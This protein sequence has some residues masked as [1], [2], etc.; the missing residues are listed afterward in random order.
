[1][2]DGKRDQGQ[3]AVA[4]TTPAVANPAEAPRR[5]T[6]LDVFVGT[7]FWPATAAQRTQHMKLWKAFAFHVLALALMPLGFTL[8]ASAFAVREYGSMWAPYQEIFYEF[9]R[10]PLEA[11]LMIL[12]GTLLPLESALFFCA[13]LFMPWGAMDER[14]GDSLRH[15]LR[16][17]WL[18]TVQLPVIVAAIV[19]VG[20]LY[21]QHEHPIDYVLPVSIVFACGLWLIWAFLRGLGARRTVPCKHR[22]PICESCGYDLTHSD[23]QGECSEC[24]EP[25]QF[26]LGMNHRPGTPWEHRARL[27]S[28]RAYWQT[29]RLAL[30][31]PTQLGRLV[32]PIP[33]DSSHLVFLSVH[34]ILLTLLGYLCVVWLY[35]MTVARPLDWNRTTVQLF[36]FLGGPLCVFAIIVVCVGIVSLAALGAGWRCRNEFRRN[37]LAAAIQVTAYQSAALVIALLYGSLTLKLSIYLGFKLPFSSLH[38]LLGDRAVFTS[39]TYLLLIIPVAVWYNVITAR[40]VRA[41]RFANDP[42]P[43]DSGVVV[44][45]DGNVVT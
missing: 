44:R 9:N 25:V 4:A 6:L 45:V 36:L 16:R 39:L 1:M 27:G 33:P 20:F 7:W 13:V 22:P 42:H 12:G 15:A 41:T 26:S 23:R 19:T 40:A 32:H 43:V 10:M 5:W 2:D 21:E 18:L 37:V 11:A 29:C 28:W 35:S 17:V 8:P 14:I 38:R 3:E 30:L 34:L 24:G 31:Q